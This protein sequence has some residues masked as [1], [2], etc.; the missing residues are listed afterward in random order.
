MKNSLFKNC[1]I[2]VVI[3]LFIGTYINS[4]IGQDAIENKKLLLKEQSNSFEEWLFDLKIRT[5]LM[6]GRFPSLSGCI[7]KNDTVV[8]S[9]GYGWARPAKRPDAD[10]VY[11][12][13]SISKS[14]TATALL[15]LYEKKMFNLTDDVNKYLD[16]KVRN[17]KF[18]E[19]NITFQMLLAHQSSLNDNDV[20]IDG[21]IS[22]MNDLTSFLGYPEYP[23]PRIMEYILPN[24]SL[25]KE[26]IWRD[27]PPGEET[28]YTS[29]SFMLLEHL[30]NQISGESLEEYCRE[31]IFKPLN[32]TNTS[33]QR[34]HF[35]RKQLA[36]PYARL[37]LLNFPLPQFQLIHA[38]S[39]LRTTVEDLSHFLIA[40]MTGGVYNGARI[41]NESTVE[42]MHR[43]QYPN[44]H[45]G[46]GWIYFDENEDGIQGHSGLWLGCDS[47]ML[48]RPSDNVGVIFFMNKGVLSAHETSVFYKI[49]QE[50]FLKAEDF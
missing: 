42:E 24:G 9:K 1:L 50:L 8:W 23:Y 41:L 19:V 34:S 44:S 3:L 10:T 32:M 36:I 38:P 22:L 17:P 48:M 49:R 29:V 13:A 14:V 11:M 45:Y 37:F 18:P 15:Q 46:L 26:S 20:L 31:N 5:L 28:Q 21:W 25:Y 39:S 47:N 27:K 33:F 43:I 16:F 7:I 4:A 6:I 40:H 12:A 30:F 2:F 35:N